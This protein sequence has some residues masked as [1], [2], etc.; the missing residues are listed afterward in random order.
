MTG[1]IFLDKLLVSIYVNK[2][3]PYQNIVIVGYKNNY[4]Q[5]K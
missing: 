1:P 4:T 3:I 5:P 2:F